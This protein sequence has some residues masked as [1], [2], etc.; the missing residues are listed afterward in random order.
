MMCDTSLTKASVKWLCI[1][2]AA[3]WNKLQ[4]FTSV[5]L[6]KM[7]KTIT[8]ETSGISLIPAKWHISLLMSDKHHF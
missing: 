5:G 8:L 2:T 1:N 4:G 3:I 6:G 7:M